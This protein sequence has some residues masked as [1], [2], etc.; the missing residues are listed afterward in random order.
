MVSYDLFLETKENLSSCNRTQMLALAALGLERLWRMFDDWTKT[1]GDPLL[2]QKPISFR[3]RARDV[4]DFLWEQLKSGQETNSHEKELESFLDF[5]N[6]SCDEMDAQDVDMGT[7]RPLLGMMFGGIS[8]FFST[9]NTRAYASEC[10]TAYAVY[11][12][13]LLFDRVYDECKES[14]SLQDISQREKE[15]LLDTK[16]NAAIAENPLWKAETERIQRDFIIV[17]KHSNNFECLCKR[18]LEIQQMD[19]ITET[20][21]IKTGSMATPS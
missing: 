5:I 6:A 12:A 17:K 3:Q 4:L 19:Y 13:D 14:V 16:I 11:L 20:F 7:G 15:K 2:Y 9:E 21:Q 10:I 8:C 18:K 1:Q